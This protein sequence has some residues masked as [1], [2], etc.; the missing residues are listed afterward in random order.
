MKIYTSFLFA[1]LFLTAFSCKKEQTEPDCP[2][3]CYAQYDV[4]G[5]PPVT[6][7]GAGTAGFLLNGEPW[8]AQGRVPGGLPGPIFAAYDEVT[9]Y[10]EISYQK[11][12]SNE[13]NE[14]SQSFTFDIMSA[15]ELNQEYAI[16]EGNALWT[17]FYG[18]DCDYPFSQVEGENNYVEI[19]YLDKEQNKVSCIFSCVL[20]QENC[21]TD[22]I[23]ITNG[24]VD[25]SYTPY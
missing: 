16:T 18:D 15:Y 5:L 17:D 20:T 6:A 2:A 7:S 23:K 21:P 14:V 22:T 10:L 8:V 3:P 9:G 1:F 12:V 24:R 4:P 25:T 11:V 19:L 13:N